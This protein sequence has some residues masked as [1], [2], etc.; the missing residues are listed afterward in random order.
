MT[1]DYHFGQWR[2]FVVW[3]LSHVQLYVTPWTAVR[4]ASILHSLLE[5]AQ[6]H[7]PLSQWCSSTTSS[8]ITHFSSCPQSFLAAGS[9]PVSMLFTSGGQIIGTSASAIV[10][11]MNMQGWFPVRLT[12]LI[13]LLSRGLSRVFSNTTVEK[14]QFFGAQ[15]SLWSSSHIHNDYWE[16]P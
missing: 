7:V 10:L 6:I 15:L 2:L 8:S 3:S 12:D 1:S 13:S 14:Q 9:F 5:F 4:Q 11:P 16:N